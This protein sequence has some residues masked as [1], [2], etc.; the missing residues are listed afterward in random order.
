MN[1]AKFCLTILAIGVLFGCNQGNKEI[2]INGEFIG[3][4]PAEIH[5]TV[6]VNGNCFWGF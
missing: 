3:D 5:Y 6:P 4:I 2:I 1:I